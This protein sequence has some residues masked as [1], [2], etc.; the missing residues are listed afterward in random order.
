MANE[1]LPIV[2]FV[3]GRQCLRKAIDKIMKIESNLENSLSELT[4]AKQTMVTWAR[5]LESYQEVPEVYKTSCRAVLENIHPFPYVVLV[6]SIRDEKH[7]KSPENL[8]CE[9][10]GTFH[11]WER[12]GNQV[13]SMSYP[14]KTI[15]A[16]ELGSVLL[17]SWL[18][19]SG[20]RGDGMA[21][22]S[23]IAFNT[24]TGRYL[25]PFIEKMRP[26]PTDMA[27]TDWQIER[28]KF[29]YLQ[30][31]NFKFMNYARES[32]VRGEKVIQSILQPKIRKH[33]FTL[34]GQKFY[35][36]VALAHLMLLTDKEI[37]FLRDDEQTTEV[38][39]E[40]Y[41]GVW[42]YISLQNI[43]AVT[44]KEMEG[45]LMTLSLTLTFGGQQMD[46][47]FEASNKQALETFQKTI[48]QLIG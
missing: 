37:I 34:F 41:G 47:V 46:K 27:D 38:K 23:T 43:T 10:D 31:I 3:L 1:N 26:A 4:G 20:L 36:T 28:S 21:S 39:G 17:A 42:Q 24:S 14:L 32:L 5:L 8:V 6:P 15:S 40:R 7:K 45:G 30:P 13:S 25:M 29:D 48:D 18:T 33:I 11:I 16:I 2:T 44:L 12:I 9:V 35:R 22:S 19:V